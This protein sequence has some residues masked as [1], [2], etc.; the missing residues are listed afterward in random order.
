MGHFLPSSL[1]L[2]PSFPLPLLCQAKLRTATSPQRAGFANLIN[3][4]LWRGISP[5]RL[6]RET[7]R[8]FTPGLIRQNRNLV[9]EPKYGRSLPPVMSLIPTRPSLARL[10]ATLPPPPAARRTV[11]RLPLPKSMEGG[12][13][14]P[15]DCRTRVLNSIKDTRF[16][17]HAPRVGSNF[18][19]SYPHASFRKI[20]LFVS[21]HPWYMA[22]CTPLGG[23][24]D[25]SAQVRSPL[26][27]LAE[28]CPAKLWARGPTTRF[29]HGTGYE[30]RSD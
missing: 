22:S 25:R 28:L 30:R 7:N 15:K 17:H 20:R 2:A 12:Q 24:K 11:L 5:C 4:L 1:C 27:F 23:D 26:V 9:Y 19:P 29:G 3:L 16:T 14:Q 13:P 8:V 10:S 18:A 21:P 6:D